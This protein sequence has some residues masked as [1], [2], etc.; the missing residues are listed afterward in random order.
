MI[1]LVSLLKTHKFNKRK[2]CNLV[3]KVG[4]GL[5]LEERRAFD[6]FKVLSRMGMACC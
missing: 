4:H 1:A 5:L 2:D 3:Y 6:F